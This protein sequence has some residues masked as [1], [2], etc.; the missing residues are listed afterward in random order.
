[1]KRLAQLGPALAAAALFTVG[2]TSETK[3]QTETRT[4]TVLESSDLHSYVMPWDYFTA[5]AN[6]KVGLAK[7]A[8]LVAQERAVNPCTL[9]IDNG[10]TIQGTPLGSRHAL[11]DTRSKHPMAVVMNQVGYDAMTVGNHDFNYGLSTLNRFAGD[12]SFPLLAA[13]VTHAKGTLPFTPYLIKTVCDVKVGIVGL[14]T[15][16]VTSWEASANIPGLTFGLPIPAAAQY[17]AEAKAA[18]AEVLIVAFHAGPDRTPTVTG[19][20]GWLT[21]PSGWVSNGSMEHENG[22]I[23]WRSRCRASTSSSRGTRIS[24]SPRCWWATPWWWS[25]VDGGATSLA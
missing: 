11:V 15:P 20:P 6:Q 8:T 17:V 12:A 24:P 25:R 2:C 23:E 14:V 22:V 5:T 13:N 16:G 4:I 3:R 1:M 18:G 7:V 10:D 9:L 21:D 19:D